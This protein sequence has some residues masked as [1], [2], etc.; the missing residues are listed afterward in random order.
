MPQRN[1]DYGWWGAVQADEPPDKQV[2]WSKTAS[3][4]LLLPGRYDIYWAQEYVTRNTPMR[5]ATDVAVGEGTM[6][7]VAAD[8]GVVLTIGDGVPQRNPDYGWWGAVQAGEPPDKLVNWSKTASALLLLP[9]R[10]DI[11]WAQEY[12]T[13]NTPMRIATDVAV[14]EGTMVPVAADSGVVL[15]IGDSVPQ[16]NSDY[17]WWGAVQAGR[18]AGQAGQLVEDGFCAA[19]A[20]GAL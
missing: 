14:G 9:G 7:P 19:A 10:Y 5:I 20:A 11:Y 15:Q 2:N 6:V 3:A 12:V 13:R 17:G 8:S 1:P 18:A 4:L 16:R